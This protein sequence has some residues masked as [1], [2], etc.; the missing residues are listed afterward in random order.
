[1]ATNPYFNRVKQVSEQDMFEANVIEAIQINGVDVWYLPRENFE[2]DPILKEPK[3]TTFQR[4]FPIEAYQP[5]AA[6]YG[7]LGQIMSEFGPRVDNITE[8][9]ISKKRFA[10]LGTG[11]TRPKE[12]D[13]IYVGDPWNPIGSYTNYMFEIN[14]CWYNNPD[15]QFGRQFTFRLVCSTFTYSYEKFHSGLPGVDAQAVTNIE[16]LLE[17]INHEVIEEKKELFIP[18]KM[19]NVFGEY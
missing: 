19:D 3:K 17:G 10:E 15:W 12:G 9:V 13:L 7:G 16:E 4:A 6:Q 1:M 11:R 5:D 2:I 14:Q 18:G 8:F